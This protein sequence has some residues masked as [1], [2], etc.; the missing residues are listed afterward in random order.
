MNQ[1]EERLEIGG[2]RKGSVYTW[3]EFPKE[4]MLWG[5]C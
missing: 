4:C 3:Q 2:Q 5:S 1:K